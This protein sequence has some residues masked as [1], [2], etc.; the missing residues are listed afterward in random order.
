MNDRLEFACVQQSESLV[1]TAKIA[2]FDNIKEVSVCSVFLV[3][4]ES[5]KMALDQFA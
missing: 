4:K 5:A 1:E 3:V 2:A